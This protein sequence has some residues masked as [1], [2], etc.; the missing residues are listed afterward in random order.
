MFARKYEHIAVYE[1]GL[2]DDDDYLTE[3]DEPAGE[4]CRDNAL[5]DL[6]VCAQAIQKLSHPH[7]VEERHV[8]TQHVAQHQSPQ[9]TAAA[10]GGDGV[11]NGAEEREHAVADVDAHQVKSELGDLTTTVRREGE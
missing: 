4:V 1:R 3:R 11:K 6:C 7:R 9:T 8:L 2:V 5:N 10:C